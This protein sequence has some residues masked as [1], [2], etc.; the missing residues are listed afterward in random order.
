M[1][2]S[3]CYV[4]VRYVSYSGVV[5]NIPG[6][7]NMM[8]FIFKLLSRFH[9]TSQLWSYTENPYNYLEA[10]MELEPLSIALVLTL[11]IT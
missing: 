3:S 10:K 11:S 6:T 8:L 7:L 2:K 5:D 4:Q 9:K 1:V